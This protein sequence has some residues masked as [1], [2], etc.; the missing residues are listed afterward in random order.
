MDKRLWILAAAVTAAMGTT[1]AYAATARDVYMDGS[2]IM[3]PRDP[4]TDGGKAGKLDVYS[5]GARIGAAP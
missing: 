4:Y 2:N 1:V 3:A 5:D